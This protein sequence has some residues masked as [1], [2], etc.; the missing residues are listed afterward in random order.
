MAQL[1]DQTLEKTVSFAEF[2]SALTANGNE[3]SL[4]KS[5]Q[6][7]NKLRKSKNLSWA[8]VRKKLV[9]L[10]QDFKAA[11]SMSPM[12]TLKAARVPLTERDWERLG[13]P[14]S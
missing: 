12:R 8:D 14:P 6:A 11:K 1:A 5:Y 3:E 9:H 13:P 4:R 7:L 2:K 10:E